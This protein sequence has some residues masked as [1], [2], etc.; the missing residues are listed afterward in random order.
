MAAPRFHVLGPLQRGELALPREAARHAQVLRLNAG[1]A[2]ALFDGHGG[3]WS[4]TILEVRRSD[5]VVQVQAHSTIERE[6]SVRVHMALGVPTNDRMDALV[7]K[8]TELGVA[9]IQPLLTERSVLRLAGERA[10]KKTAHWQAVAIAACEQCG[11]NRV[12][13]VL[14]M[15]ALPLWLD[16][17]APRGA[18]ERRVLLSTTTAAIQPN[19]VSATDVCL[20]S[21]PEGGLSPRKRQ[22]PS[23]AALRPT[24]WGHAFCAPTP[25][26]WRCSW[27]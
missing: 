7:E 27:C 13:T 12:P 24:P 19:F 26:R 4:A 3:E 10:A 21:G 9:T 22:S 15:M 2:V 1:D 25:H 18:D 6:A 11:R 5:V 20:L 16:G 23:S 14:P 8:A 17:L